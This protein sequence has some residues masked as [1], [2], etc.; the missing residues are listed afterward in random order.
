MPNALNLDSSSFAGFLSSVVSPA[1]AEQN[2]LWNDDLLAADVATIS[3]ENS[4][5]AH[6]RYRP[7]S[8][9]EPQPSLAA[10]PE[11]DS[12][13]ET[14]APAPPSATG[15][16]DLK[17]A[18]ITIRMSRAECAQLRQRSAEAGMTVSAYLRSCTFEAE[19]LRG[20]VKEA[21]AELR[22]ATASGN[23]PATPIQQHKKFD[24]LL[25]IIPR[26]GLRN[27]RAIN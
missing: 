26:V 3:Y 13:C 11:P 10:S 12:A 7:A 18:S 2:D 17:S 27:Q 4:L 25:R 21:L 16:D 24:W 6:S 8:E 1:P 20:Q 23:Q 9:P 15:P 19:A 5:K 14:Q 22:A